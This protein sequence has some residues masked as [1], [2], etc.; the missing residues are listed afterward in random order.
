VLSGRGV[1]TGARL[2]AGDSRFLTGLP[3]FKS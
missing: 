3:M 1:N 2:T